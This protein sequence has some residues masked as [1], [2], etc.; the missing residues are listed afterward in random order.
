MVGRYGDGRALGGLVWVSVTIIGACISG[1]EDG[2]GTDGS[3]APD[4]ATN[5]DGRVDG[6]AASQADVRADV[7]ETG[8]E[9]HPPDEGPPDNR[10]PDAIPTC[11]SGETRPCPLPECP[12]G[13]QLCVGAT[14]SEN[15]LGETEVCNGLDDDCDGQ[16]DD[17]VPGV[18]EIC[19]VGVGAC[20]NEGVTACNAHS[21]LVCNAQPLE[22]G[23]EVCDGIDN[24][25]DTEVDESDE[26]DEDGSALFRD[27]YA[28]PEGTAGQGA[29]VAGQ[30]LC[31][32]GAYSECVGEILPEEEICSGI[33]DD[34]DGDTDEGFE[35]FRVI[36]EGICTR[37]NRITNDGADSR[38]P[39]LVW[40]GN[41][42]GLSWY[43]AR[44]R[45]HEVYFASLDIDGNR[46]GDEVVVSDRNGAHSDFSSIVWNGD[47]YGLSWVDE[48]DGNLEIYFALIDTDG[49]KLSDNIRVTSD[50]A[51]SHVPAL[52]WN[53]NGYGLSWGDDRDG[54]FDIYFALIDNNGNKIGDNT[55]VTS[56]DARAMISS[57]VW[58]DN[59][60]GLSWY[61]YNSHDETP[62]V[63]F[64]RLDVAGNKIGDDI[65]VNN[66]DSGTTP[67]LVWNGNGYGLSWTDHRHG[68]PQIYFAQLDT[69]GST[70]GNET[71][72]STSDAVSARSSLVWNGNGY[73]V[74]WNDVQDR[75]YE[76]YFA[77]LDINGNKIGND[78]WLVN[79]DAVSTAPSLVW[80]GSDYGLSWTDE[81]DG[82]EE[83]YFARI[84]ADDA[85]MAADVP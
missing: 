40:N 69:D 81:R 51:N 24:D 26:P 54:N 64:A 41:G 11:A 34:C 74:S 3:A 71:R 33:D 47:G 67:A 56:N 20:V 72:I 39:A 21:Q 19:T 12:A 61:G 28:G 42:Y 79:D 78:V 6:S 53:G 37:E 82:N 43:D 46:I 18:G 65:R 2:V 8:V 32:D 31:V 38:E 59:G 13:E 4:A 9:G 48:R 50:D 44:D 15:C 23:E 5:V 52:V 25:C 30:Q 45:N 84:L 70:I 49:N 10:L 29:C 83:I 76:I 7:P 16:I 17:G 27:C 22:P 63:Y 62:H 58:N 36:E 57:L 80:N 68:N 75:N 1:P 77:L 14:W 66:S 35:G 73:C 55:Q 60:Y 85:A